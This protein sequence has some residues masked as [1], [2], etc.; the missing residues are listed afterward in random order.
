MSQN[1]RRVVSMSE[2]LRRIGPAER[3]HTFRDA[4]LALVGADWDRADLIEAMMTYG[5]EDSGPG[6]S[7]MRHT[8]CLRDGTGWL[9]IEAEPSDEEAT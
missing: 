4:G 2:A 5:V 9:F 7:R 1:E 3:I 6:A 8:L